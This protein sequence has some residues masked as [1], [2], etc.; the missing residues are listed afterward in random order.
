MAFG[1]MSMAFTFGNFGTLSD[2]S[3]ESRNCRLVLVT[4]WNQWALECVNFTFL[5]VYI[6]PATGD[7]EK[8]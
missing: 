2:G 8:N 7:K 1:E 4:F 5:K 6:W 3:P